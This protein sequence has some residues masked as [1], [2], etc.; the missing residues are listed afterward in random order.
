MNTYDLQK[1]TSCNN[2]WQ[3]AR[4]VEIETQYTLKLGAKGSD[5]AVKD[6]ES[7]SDNDSYADDGNKS[8]IDYIDFTVEEDREEYNFFEKSIFSR[9]DYGKV[10][11]EAY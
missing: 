3:I 5:G 10:G 8:P 1:S 11:H 4:K 9:S 7:V 6:S 2:R